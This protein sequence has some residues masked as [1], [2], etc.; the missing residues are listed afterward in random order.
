MIKKPFGAL[1]SKGKGCFRCVDRRRLREFVFGQR[2]TVDLNAGR[3][4]VLTYCPPCKK[5]FDVW[6]KWIG[7]C[8]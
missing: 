7:V 4:A 2:K 5:D 8:I 1:E 3:E 6:L